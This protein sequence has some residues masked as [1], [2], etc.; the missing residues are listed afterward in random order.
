[1][2]IFAQD[3]FK[4]IV[5]ADSDLDF[6]ATT[7]PTFGASAENVLSLDEIGNQTWT[8]ARFV[9]DDAGV[10]VTGLVLDL[11]V[12]DGNDINSGIKFMPKVQNLAADAEIAWG[13][14]HWQNGQNG[15]MIVGSCTLKYTASTGK[16][17]LHCD[18]DSGNY[19]RVLLEIGYINDSFQ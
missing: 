1:M 13:D 10:G 9:F 7:P 15:T 12:F 19:D 14:S 8:L 18:V 6:T 3:E 2:P 17:S 5:Y 11:K 4:Y 16:Y